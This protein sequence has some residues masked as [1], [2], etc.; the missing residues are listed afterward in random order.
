MTATSAKFPGTEVNTDSG[1]AAWSTGNAGSSNNVY[2]LVTPLSGAPTDYLDLTNFGFLVGDVPAGAIIDGITVAIERKRNASFDPCNDST[3]QLILAGTAQGDNKATA[4]DWPTSDT[5]ATYGG[6]ADKWGLS[7][8]QAQVIASNF[9]VRISIVDPS[10]TFGASATIDGVTIVINYTAGG[11]ITGTVAVT[12]SGLV[13][14]AA[15]DVTGVGVAGGTGRRSHK[16]SVVRED[17]VSIHYREWPYQRI[18]I[19]R[20][21]YGIDRSYVL[22]DAGVASFKINPRDGQANPE[23]LHMGNRIVIEAPDMPP[24]V[25]VLTR[26]EEGLHDPT[27]GISALGIAAMLDARPTLQAEVYTTSK[28]SGAIFT[29]ILRTA[30]RQAYTGIGLS[31]K[32]PTGPALVDFSLGGQSALQSLGELHQRTN[33]EWW[34]DATVNPYGIDCIARWGLGQGEDYSNLVHLYEGRH[35]TE[36]TYQLDMSHVKDDIQ[37]IGGTGAVTDRPFTV[38]SVGTNNRLRG[39]AIP[40]ERLKRAVLGYGTPYTAGAILD[41]T[42]TSINELDRRS[43]RIQERSLILA[44]Q[45]LVDVNRQA[46]WSSLWCGNYITIHTNTVLS[47][48]L[49]KVVRITGVQP[50]AE[51]GILR[52]ALEVSIR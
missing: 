48:P 1:G 37:L 28:G 36:R 2:D 24:W 25:G 43:G 22:M 47:G 32:E 10:V 49:T 27:I 45:L 11:A 52:L 26:P 13:A 39:G 3:I 41:P 17:V 14:S 19:I 34:I 50:S 40:N 23:T 6:A 15:G 30:N 21:A 5:V 9:G 18:A 38:K 44:E 46:D 35:F 29:S 7:P 42:I 12:L 31:A 4:T 8:T 51:R 20:S 33:Y 16:Q